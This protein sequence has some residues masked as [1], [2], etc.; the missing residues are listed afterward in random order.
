MSPAIEIKSTL[1]TALTTYNVVVETKVGEGQKIE[2]AEVIFKDITVYGTPDILK[3][4]QINGNKDQ[5]DT[6]T[7]NT[8]RLSHDYLVQAYLT[9]DKYRY[10]SEQII[11]RSMK[12]NFTVDVLPNYTYTD[13]NNHIADFV[14]RSSHFTLVVDYMN[15]FKSKSVEV[16]L[17]RTI[18]LKHTLDFKNYWSGDNLV[19]AGSVFVPNEID[20][21]VYEVYVY[22]DGLEF[23]SKSNIKILKGSWQ[24]IDP[25]YHGD[26]LGQ[27][28]WFV[29]NDN[30]FLFGGESSTKLPVWK[31][32]ITNNSWERKRDFRDNIDPSKYQI[33][34]FDLQYKNKA[35]V[36]FRNDQDLEIWKYNDDSDTW[37]FVT[38]YPGNGTQYLTSFISRGKLFLGGGGRHTQSYVDYDPYYDFWEYDLDFDHWEQKGDIPILL[39]TIKLNNARGGTLSCAI[40][41]NDVYVFSYSNDFWL[42]H[43]ETDSWSKKKKFPGH[44]RVISNLVEKN[45]K[46]YLIGGLYMDS[47]YV[48]LKDCWEYSEDSNSWELVAF[49][50]ELY[51]NGIAFTF[52]DH[53]YAGLGWVISGYSSFYEQNF[54]QFDL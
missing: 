21:G 29:K 36:L 44:I 33:Q 12:N 34:S 10:T 41:E 9:T 51:A 18:P 19:T 26:P 43:T 6:I 42:Y 17:N 13:F 30:A 37:S 8:N 1:S 22:L 40:N 39:M 49:M 54:Y 28:A 5:I 32:N 27:Y 45:D 15:T 4:I 52:N 25:K 31:Y 35:Y 53:I 11:I 23:K 38:K 47:G 24:K 2:K 46:L 16:K 3:E 50:P 20:A 48:G 7:I 14:N